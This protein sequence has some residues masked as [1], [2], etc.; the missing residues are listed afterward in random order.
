M[1]KYII[2]AI[3][4]FLT[5]E[6]YIGSTSMTLKKRM[7][8]HT[9]FDNHT[10]SKDIINRDCYIAYIIDEIFDTAENLNIQEVYY[11]NLYNSVNKNKKLNTF[12]YAGKSKSKYIN[13]PKITCECGSTFKKI[14]IRSHINSKK[15]SEFKNLL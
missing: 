12:K 1:K 5:G 11:M 15:H 4:C 3:E 13:S 9:G 7:Q 8:K 14:N 2:Y 10:A 6:T